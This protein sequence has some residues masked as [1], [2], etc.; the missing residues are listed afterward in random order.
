MIALDPVRAARE[1]A[2]A[3]PDRPATAVL[4]DTED[5]R[6]VVFRLTT[7]QSVPPHRSPSSVL[8]SVLSG[9]GVLSGEAE[10][11]TC[12]PGDTVAYAPTELHGMRAINGELLLMAT[13]TP[14]PGSRARVATDPTKETE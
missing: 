10:E 8:L 6:V 12:A 3:H 7:G 9:T 13:I 11:R 14:R 2:A 1:A 4:L 5:V